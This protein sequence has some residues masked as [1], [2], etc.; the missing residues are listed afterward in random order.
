MHNS[1]INEYLLIISLFNNFVLF[2]K[3]LNS[4][5]AAFIDA[6]SSFETNDTF[7]S[8]FFNNANLV[9]LKDPTI[10]S[11][12]SLYSNKYHFE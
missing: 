3:L 12:E 5:Y 9:M 8:I 4:L 6:I 10:N 7:H 11:Y 2:H 1:N